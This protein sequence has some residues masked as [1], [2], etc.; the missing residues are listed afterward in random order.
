M[1]LLLVWFGV[2]SFL[3]LF[4]LKICQASIYDELYT[5]ALSLCLPA[6]PPTPAR[7]FGRAFP[8]D[9]DDFSV[10]VHGGKHIKHFKVKK[11]P[12]ENIFV[13]G[14]RTFKTL[15]KL[16]EF[17]GTYS[18]YTTAPPDEEGICLEYPMKR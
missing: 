10:S 11:N 9:K 12:M 4:L 17:Y 16:V 7:L 13:F 6:C 18:I 1:L 8:Q 2:E 14:E 5:D 3:R 15:L